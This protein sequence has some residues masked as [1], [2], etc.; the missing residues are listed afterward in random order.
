[1]LLKKLQI[2]RFGCLNDYSAE[3]QPGL[4]I[5]RGPNESGKS[6]LHQALLIVLTALPNQN[7][8]NGVWRAWDSDRWFWLQLTFADPGGKEYQITKDFQVGSQELGLPNGGSTA[9]RDEIE[10][11][12][13]Q[14]LG[15]SSL[16]MLRS[17]LCVEQD[18]LA[19]ITSGRTEIAHSLESVVTGGEDDV[20]TEQALKRLD[21]TMREFRVGYT[22]MAARPGPLARKRDRQAEME[23]KVRKYQVKFRDHESDERAL[24]AAEN[25]L[26]EIDQQLGPLRTTLADANRLQT[27]Q[28]SLAEWQHREEALHIKLTQIESAED[29]LKETEEA[30]LALGPVAKMTEAE[31]SVYDQLVSRARTLS[32][33]YGRHQEALAHHQEDLTEYQ[34]RQKAY[35]TSYAVYESDLAAYQKA[36]KGYKADLAAY[37]ASVA[38]YEN[39]LAAYQEARRPYE[40]ALEAQREESEKYEARR[41]AYQQELAT[42][43]EEL[44]QYNAVKVEQEQ[45]I[46]AYE[47]AYEEYEGQLAAY[48]QKRDRNAYLSPGQ[49]SPA[50]PPAMV[51]SWLVLLT[52]GVLAAMLGLALLALLDEGESAA[53]GLLALGVILALLGLWRRGQTAADTLEMDRVT[54]KKPAPGKM[55]LPKPPQRPRLDPLIQPSPPVPPQSLSTAEEILQPLAQKRPQKPEI[56]QPQPP[57]QSRPELPAP[58]PPPPN[59]PEYDQQPLLSAGQEI[60]GQ[61][62]SAGCSDV[63]ELN[64]RYQRVIALR[65]QKQQ[66]RSRLEGLIGYGT[67]KELEEQRREASRQRRDTQEVLDEPGLQQAAR[68]TPLQ[69]NQLAAEI[70]NLE[71]QQS[72][73]LNEQQRLRFQIEQGPGSAEDL[74]QAEEALDSATMAYDRAQERIDV[75]QLT[76]DILDRARTRTLKQAQ[77]RLGPQTATYLRRLTHGRYRQAWIDSDLRIKLADPAQ[78]D[79]RIRP[80]QLSRGAQDQL[81]LAARLALVDLLFPDTWPPILLDDPFVHFDPQRLDAAIKMCNDIAAERQILLFTCSNNYNQV[82]HHIQMPPL[83]AYRQNS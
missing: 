32:E 53:I 27:V 9:N 6:T 76:Y 4:N 37:N 33:E 17:T 48:E 21:K 15:S 72:E 46:A 77:E 65:A 47:Q 23:E 49:D 79:R 25:R 54:A 14:I 31:K 3:F 81:Y 22:R 69:V 60:K 13:G 78:P 44:E 29:K 18:A 52:I 26:A 34:E 42:Y 70:E 56:E 36:E 75:Y 61:I 38:R 74:L 41:L 28:E 40:A 73:L 39:E 50:E 58:L 11:V 24:E 7:K 68:M 71:E 8:R 16:L 5:I 19:D 59:K 12:I 30:L 83:Q 66:A 55:A 57:A 45:V 2:E 35:D 63:A 80:E 10:S 62:Q 20:F 43:K 1:M 82:G 67:G 64:R 51:P